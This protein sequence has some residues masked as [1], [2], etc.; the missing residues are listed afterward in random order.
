MNEKIDYSKPHKIS[1]ALEDRMLSESKGVMEI[2]KTVDENG[3][4]KVK[5][6]PMY[7]EFYTKMKVETL[8]KNG[9]VEK[10]E[11]VPLEK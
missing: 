10:T 8:D 11:Y 4:V 3:K 2:V 9:K 5:Y 1:K 7:P 6:I